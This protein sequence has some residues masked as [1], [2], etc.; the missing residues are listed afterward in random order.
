MYVGYCTISSAR[1]KGVDGSKPIVH[2]QRIPTSRSVVGIFFSCRDK[3]LC[4]RQ[5]K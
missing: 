1:I 4:E 2:K 5:E 3:K